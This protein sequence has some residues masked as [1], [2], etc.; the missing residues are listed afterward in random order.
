MM[1]SR[2][3]QALPLVVLAAAF[4]VAGLL[5]AQA[6]AR[7]NDNPQPLPFQQN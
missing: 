5:L 4:A 7:A 6:I 3:S 1:E 2:I